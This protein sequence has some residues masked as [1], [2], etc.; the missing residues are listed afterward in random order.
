[1]KFFAAEQFAEWF[2]FHAGKTPT[3]P[4]PY[5]AAGLEE[6]GQ[7]NIEASFHLQAG[8]YLGNHFRSEHSPTMRIIL[9]AYSG[10]D[11]RLKYNQLKLARV[12]LFYFGFAF[13]F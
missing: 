12:K 7:Q 11:P 10:A 9:G 1:M 4:T 3:D 6:Y 8:V 2:P 13:N 5:L